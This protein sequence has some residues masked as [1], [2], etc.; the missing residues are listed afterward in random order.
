[1]SL[2][3]GL[4]VAWYG[5]DFTGSAAVL[6]VLAQA[7]VDSVL[8]LDV[9]TAEGLSRFPDARAIGIAGTARSQTP[10]QMKESLPRVFAALAGMKAHIS[11]Y[12]ICSTLDSSP[13]IGSIGQAVELAFEHFR[14]AVVPCLVAAP[15]IRRWQCFGSLF[16]AASGGVFRLDR[17]PVM[18]RHPVTPMDEA[19]VITHLSRQ[20][21]LPM[22]LIDVEDLAGDCKAARAKLAKAGKRIAVLDCVTDEHLE[23][24]GS[25]IWS[26]RWPD[27]LALGSQGV[28]Y[29]L[30]A[31]WRREGL[32][33]PV[34]PRLGTDKAR[35]AVVS[36]SVAP[37]TAGQIAWADANGFACIALDA[38]AVVKGGDAA[39]RAMDAARIAALSA[40]VQGA[41]PLIYTARGPDDPAVRATRNAAGYDPQANDRVG[42]ALGDLL[43]DI[44]RKT[45]LRRAVISGGDTSGHATQRLGIEALTFVAPTIPGA[46]LFRAHANNTE[47]DGLELALKGG[48]MG[49]PDYFGQ[50]RQG[51]GTPNI[52]RL[53]Q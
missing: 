1:M 51:G 5:D 47:F 50:I 19:D 36:G 43:A 37:V 25:L 38:A 24:I 40:F 10:A 11:H 21:K 44:L 17:H 26:N 4:L 13:Q 45:G 42:V 3:L 2:P 49:S 29:A 48:Q 9:P 8:F 41:D 6:E 52:G 32:L 46:G 34:Q 12:K 39:A 14:E 20:T 27:M 7:G 16:A 23:R 28:E 33:A 18:A 22:E 31:H 53:A 35:L 30:V 15:A